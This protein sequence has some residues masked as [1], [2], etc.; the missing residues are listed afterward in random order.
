MQHTNPTSPIRSGFDYQNYWSLDICGKWLAD[1]K[2]YEWIQFETCPDEDNPNRFYLDDI[3]CLTSNGLFHF[4]QAKHRQD[5]EN[6]WTWDDLLT[7]KL[8][9]GKSIVK[10]WTD[11]LL[12]RIDKCETAYFV[13]DG[14]H[15]D[16]IA[17]YLNGE[18]VDILKIKSQA[19]TLYANLVKEIGSEENVVAVIGK[20]HF[21]FRQESLSDFE[22]RTRRF[23]YENLSATESGVTN[24]YYE[25]AKECRQ[26]HPRR[27]AIDTLR[28]W[29]QFDTPRPLEEQFEIPA[30]FEFFDSKTHQLLLDKFQKPEGGIEV[31]Y[32]KPGAGKSVYL[33]KLD[34]ELRACGV[35][36]VKHHYHISPQ[37]PNPQDRLNADR[38][39]EAL[40]SQL[41]SHKEELGELANRDSGQIPI[42]EFIK[43]VA[44]SLN[45]KG[46]A[47][48]VIIDGLDHVLRYGDKQDLERFLKATCVPQPGVW[49]VIGMQ[50]VA[51]SHLPQIV[52]DKSPKDQWIEI[53]GLSRDAV[54]HLIN[55][56][57]TE[58]HLPDQPELLRALENKL[59][60]ITAGNPL[61]L[62]YSLKQLK[63]SNGNALVTEYL[64][65]D[66]IPYGD[67]IEKYYD[68]LWRQISANAKTILL[69]IV[70]VN[71]RFTEKQLTECVSLS[72][73]IP[74]EITA[75]FKQ[76]SHLVLKNF[77]NQMSVYHNSFNVFLKDQPEMEQQ[78]I[79]IKTNVRKWLEQSDYE[80][81]KWAELK[82]IKHELGNSDALLAIDRKWLIDSICYPCNFDQI[83]NQ[84]TLAT[85][86]A[87]QK[88]DLIKGFQISNLHTYYVNSRQFVEEAPELIWKET[89]FNNP[90][91]FEFVDLR[92][93]SIAV[94][95]DLA[96]IADSR[97]EYKIVKEIIDVL[98][99]SQ[100]GQEY[101]HDTIP[102][103]SV[104]L[105]RAMTLD[106]GHKLSR[107]HKYI[108]G[109]RDLNVTDSLFRIYA[110]RLLAL[111]Q[112]EKL[113]TL[114]SLDLNKQERNA[115]LEEC[116]KCGLA[117][118]ASDISPYFSGQTDLP[119][120]GRIYQ[121]LKNQSTD[122]SL[123][124]PS[125]DTF[126]L[127]IPEH[128]FEARKNW[129][130]LFH[131]SFLVGLLYCL[132]GKER[133]IEQW[134]ADAPD[135]WTARAVSC[136][137]RASIRIAS[138]IKQSR[139]AYTD[140]FD[141]LSNMEVLKWPEDRA[142][143]NFQFA[144]KNA[145]NDIL[146]EIIIV[147]EY[148][149]D[150]STI[151][152]PDYK[153]II[154]KP[155]FF[156]QDDLIAIVL[157]TNRKLFSDDLYK[158]IRD[159]KTAKLLKVVST[160]PDRAKEY[161]N[162]SKL[163]R[164]YGDL[165]YAQL[166]L[167]KAADNVLGYGYHKDIYLFEVLDAIELCTRYG[168]DAGKTN[169][170]VARVIPLIDNVAEYTDGDETNHLPVKLAD[171]LAQQN[172]SL[173]RKY[174]HQTADQEKFYHCEEL[175]KCLL[176]SFSFVKE[177]EITLAT[178]AL[179]KGS[180][181]TLKSI[182]E[183]NNAAKL[184]F[185]NIQSY[186]GEISYPD[187]KRGEDYAGINRSVD[188]SIIDPDH[189]LDYL[190]STLEHQYDRDNYLAGWLSYWLQ[191][192]SIKTISIVF[193][194]IVEKFGVENISGE[195]L[196]IIYPVIYEFNA[197]MAFDLLCKAQTN[198]Y[199]WQRYWTA[200]SKAENRWK[201]IKEKYPQ[202]YV[203]FFEKSAGY[204]VPLS[205]G[206]EFFL[207]FSDFSRAEA[208]TEASVAFAESLMAD[209]TLPLPSWL[210]EEKEITVLDI[211]FQ[212]LI[213]PSPL[214]RERTAT[215][216]ANLLFSSENKKE[217]FNQLLLWIEQQKMET[218][219]AM[220]LLPI[221]KAYY[222]AP[223]RDDLTYMNIRNIARAV[224]V[225]SEVIERLFDEISLLIGT[226][227]PNLPA[228]QN[229]D[230]APDSYTG[231]SFFLK[232][233]NT[234]L[235]PIYMQ[236]AQDI[237]KY[238]AKQFVKHWAFIA[239]KIITDA[240][241]NVDS[242]QVYYY[243]HHEHDEFLTGF[244]PGISEA[245]RSAFLRLLQYFYANENIHKEFY[246]EYVYSTLPIELSRWKMFP[247][248]SPKWWPKFAVENVNSS[249]EQ[250]KIV[251]IIFNDPIEKL[252]Q[253]REGNLLIAAQGAIEPAEGWRKADP[254]HSFRLI[255]FG[256]QVDGPELPTAE[257]VIKAIGY[258]PS[259]VVIPSMTTRPF[260]FLEDTR[261]HL[262]I[263]D[264]PIR[265][266]NLTIHPII[267]YE[268]DLVISL[269][270]FFRDYNPSINLNP[271]LK[272]DLRI[273]IHDNGWEMQDKDGGMI[274][275]Y[276]DWLEG[277]K[278]RYNR[279]MPIPH[280][281]HLM[282][283]THFINKWLED[284][285]LRLG[286]VLKTTYRGKK[287]PSDEV[288]KYE[289]T[290]L[291]NV[292]SIIF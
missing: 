213:W 145:I 29:C 162:L 5:P 14:L 251:P 284:N 196:D 193:Q 189:I 182:A 166:L 50:E 100:A 279:E 141:C 183:T 102:V 131:T 226:D 99:E 240:S 47:L 176:K 130:Q 178:T 255:S 31:I 43:T 172:P 125:R 195:V 74:A 256:Y 208:I 123:T 249:Q 56:N 20:L 8:V 197:A 37:D 223:S 7:T 217:V 46:K 83:S 199:G 4:Y 144:L 104:A 274:A 138:G 52:F 91:I 169:N 150:N 263:K 103:I 152:I 261:N 76:I 132:I 283:E 206:V 288:K 72:V 157:D 3:V 194:Q 241:V 116:A 151:G 205:R 87:C 257:E 219:V 142:S 214:V 275:K 270:Q 191:N 215:G 97:G 84:M 181:F 201:F 63:N 60:D 207:L 246:L 10:K 6:R 133:E 61:H 147:K 128:D 35:I 224:L 135:L 273:L 222:V 25:I 86:V 173:L 266:R 236:R 179:E 154:S 287:Y 218:T 239:D 161:S 68:S 107:V 136:L 22:K 202:R 126:T 89:F 105:L 134:I 139:I 280:G 59:F 149:S 198:G 242:N 85:Q 58:I 229:V 269:W 34:D 27:L 192:A 2:R 94:L 53:K 286:Y 88:G 51:E 81:L 101:R 228:F 260:N 231:S 227:K 122:L 254:S 158:K 253:E 120:I 137:L 67:G 156:D 92:S 44:A 33:S 42:S 171:L 167:I 23:F 41:K 127:T 62:R 21:V 204:H 19:P 115:I 281:Q 200:K 177:E 80:Y 234:F 73:A 248:R 164:I 36:S 168:T 117:N 32:G 278:E 188:Y 186:L 292:S 238:S 153:T 245:Y 16:E 71:F 129:Q 268:K 45:R 174:Y 12:P 114:I 1:P 55:L 225:N 78:R 28:K 143:L 271:L 184:A 18:L 185:D 165:N 285:H 93:L 282:V 24:L 17:Q 277:L 69:N 13:T 30:D 203:D 163:A 259:L 38:V 113:L 210:K 9:H 54:S 247:N 233:V 155:P 66:L 98:I 121:V 26:R 216:L 40:K 170:W 110:N 96:E 267:V 237:E 220:G 265:I 146:G 108:L 221:I 289:D 95:P 11:S 276:A 190:N 75:G 109:L 111:G 232:Y 48:V 90:S 272:K 209:L 160:F 15:S 140:I 124:L 252:I 112:T 244:S 82:I 70:S 291:I 65:D 230:L 180:L 77:R 212:R 290:K 148:L 118:S 79:V 262:L 243:A 49:I 258:T 106:R 264:K 39:I 64:C 119:L 57:K 235:A 187:D 159:E 211:L 250:D 175:F